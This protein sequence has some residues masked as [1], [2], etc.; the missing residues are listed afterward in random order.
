MMLTLIA[1]LVPPL[2]AVALS[3]YATWCQA[4]AFVG[5]TIPLVGWRLEGG[6]LTALLWAL[7]VSG[8]ISWGARLA[9]RFLLAA[10]GLV[11]PLTIAAAPRADRPDGSSRD[12]EADGLPSAP[13]GVADGYVPGFASLCAVASRLVYQPD[14]QVQNMLG[15]LQAAGLSL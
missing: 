9:L 6:F 2:F 10:I 13:E 14:E 7:G 11:I 3:V 15:P 12:D 5:G 4:I 8:F 1:R